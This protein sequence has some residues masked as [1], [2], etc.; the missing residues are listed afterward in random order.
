MMYI[1]KRRLTLFLSK[2]FSIS[3]CWKD[4][5][6]HP[7]FSMSLAPSPPSY[8]IPLE[9]SMALEIKIVIKSKGL[10][11]VLIITRE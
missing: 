3:Y 11:R 2:V 7:P 4:S 8:C 5:A 1:E 10:K 6:L 9:L